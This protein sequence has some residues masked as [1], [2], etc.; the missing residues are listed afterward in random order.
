MTEPAVPANV[1][2]VRDVLAKLSAMFPKHRDEI[3]AWSQPYQR[4]L[5]HLPPARLREVFA[6][7]I[8]GWDKSYPPKPAE[9]KSKLGADAKPET[10]NSPQDIANGKRNRALVEASQRRDRLAKKLVDDS[11]AHYAEHFTEAARRANVSADDLRLLAANL[12]GGLNP[13]YKDPAYKAAAA[14]VFANEPLPDFLPLT[15]DDWHRLRA[16]ATKKRDDPSWFSPDRP[17][18][19]PRPNEARRRESLLREEAAS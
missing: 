2:T 15:P 3:L 9:F 18:S 16:A 5:G 13:T 6:A 8:D 4:T 12:W 7:V 19:F 17:P 11:L 1:D 10:P 14:H